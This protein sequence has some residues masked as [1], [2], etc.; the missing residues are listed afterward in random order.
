M[1]ADFGVV[2]RLG[3]DCKWLQTSELWHGLDWTA[4]SCRLR[5]LILK[6]TSYYNC[7]LKR[8]YTLKEACR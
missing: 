1:I 2:A 6:K 8:I 3:L 7:L 5:T 4:N